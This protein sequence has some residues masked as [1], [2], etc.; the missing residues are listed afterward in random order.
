MQIYKYQLEI[1][2]KQTITLPLGAEILSAQAQDGIVCIWVLVDPNA[3]PQPQDIFIFGTGHDIAPQQ[4]A[5]M[6]FVGTVQTPPL[7]WHIFAGK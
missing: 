3:A 5:R 7:V 2:K 4:L 6:K 1:T